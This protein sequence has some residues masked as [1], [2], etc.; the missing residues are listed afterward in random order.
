MQAEVQAGIY[1]TLDDAREN[2]EPALLPTETRTNVIQ[3][4]NRWGFLPKGTVARLTERTIEL[5][6]ND[7]PTAPAN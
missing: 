4:F 6:A 2:H 1:R 5:H 7:Q 3:A